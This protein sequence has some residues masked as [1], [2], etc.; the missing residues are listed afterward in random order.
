MISSI[1]RVGVG[2]LGF[3]KFGFND[4]SHSYFIRFDVKIGLGKK[5]KD[6]IDFPHAIF[7]KDADKVKKPFIVRS[8]V[9]NTDS[10]ICNLYFFHSGFFLGLLANSRV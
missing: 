9:C 6:E 2:K 5:T 7:L 1:R 4:F 10:Q 8:Q 3:N